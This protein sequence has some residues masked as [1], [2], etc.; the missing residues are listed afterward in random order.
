MRR[1][2]AAAVAAIVGLLAIAPVAQADYY[3]SKRRAESFTRTEVHDRY[4]VDGHTG[5]S[6]RPQGAKAARPGYVYHR[7]T[8]AWVDDVSWGAFLI[9]G[10]SRGPNWY[11]VKLLK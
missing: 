4:I 2:L 10:N 1:K 9:A 11:F 5:V 8:C 7:W 3:I 6:C